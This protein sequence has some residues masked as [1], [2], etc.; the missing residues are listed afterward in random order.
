MSAAINECGAV[1]HREHFMNLAALY[2]SFIA[3]IESL[4]TNHLRIDPVEAAAT[5]FAV[6]LLANPVKR[7]KINKMI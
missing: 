7:Q 1:V 4:Q 6:T 5:A 3:A 2:T